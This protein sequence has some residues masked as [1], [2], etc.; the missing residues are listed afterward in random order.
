MASIQS[1]PLQA[2]SYQSRIHRGSVFTSF[3]APASSVLTGHVERLAIA[4]DNWAS[5]GRGPRPEDTKKYVL[6]TL[7]DACARAS[8]ESTDTGLWNALNEPPWKKPAQILLCAALV[9][10]IVCVAVVYI[11]GG[12]YIAYPSG[13]FGVVVGYAITYR[14]SLVQTWRKAAAVAVCTDLQSGQGA[15]ELQ[16]LGFACTAAVPPASRCPGCDSEEKAKEG[17][18]LEL[19]E[20]GT[21]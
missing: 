5:A 15:S 18:T 6:Q 3:H 19:F 16:R 8:S 17:P 9:L 11:S 13:G 4:A 14:S 1:N 2:S 10:V 12:R 20:V 7:A 21:V